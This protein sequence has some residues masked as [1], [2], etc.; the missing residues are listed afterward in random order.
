MKKTFYM[1]SVAAALLAAGCNK[2]EQPAAAPSE[3][4]VPAEETDIVLYAQDINA[5][6]SPAMKTVTAED[7]NGKFTVNWLNGDQIAV[8]TVPAGTD[9]TTLTLA[10]WQASQPVRFKTDRATEDG[11]RVFTLNETDSDA[12]KVT[13]FKDRYAAGNLDWYAVYPGFMDTPSYAGQGMIAFGYEENGTPLAVQNGNSTMAHLA[14]QDVLFGKAENT[15]EPTVNMEHLGTLMSFTVQNV[16]EEEFIVKSITIVAPQGENIA[17]QFRLHL[18]E[19]PAFVGSEVRNPKNEYTLS[20]KGGEA[21]P[22]GSSAKFY[23]ILAPFEIEAGESATIT[24][25]TD[26]GD[27][28]KTMTVGEKGLAF[29]AGMKNTAKLNVDKLLLE[30]L[31]EHTGLNVRFSNSHNNSG[32]CLVNLTDATLQR[33]GDVAGKPEEQEKLDIAAF[34]GTNGTVP[35]I[36]APDYQYVPYDMVKAWSIRNSTK[37]LVLQKANYDDFTT[38]SQI[39]VRFNYAGEPRVDIKTGDVIAAKLANGNYA[40]IQ[41]VEFKYDTAETPLPEYVVLNVKT[42]K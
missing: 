5:I 3:P 33:Q 12:K 7:E 37:L 10:D 8:Y 19:E 24:V 34:A 42:V 1:V 22:A 15:K 26:K 4:Q 14:R 29:E 17:G 28:F 23:Q 9:P 30:P 36:S 40:L 32:Y 13:A 39:A 38:P 21:I 18:S 41:V 20:V 6:D 27:W 25:N 2:S 11:L 31:I 35:A 16:T